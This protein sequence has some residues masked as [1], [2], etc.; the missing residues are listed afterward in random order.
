MP[1]DANSLSQSEDPN[2]PFLL[3][4][5]Q[6]AID[7]RQKAGIPLLLDTVNDNSNGCNGPQWPPRLD[8]SPTAEQFAQIIERHVPVLI[9]GCMQG[10]TALAQWRDSRYLIDRMGGKDNRVTVALTPNGRADDLVT[11][12]ETGKT[13]FA[14]PCEDQMSF[15]ELFEQFAR[16]NETST[17]Y[18]GWIAY[19]QSQNSNLSVREYGDLSPLLSDLCI[20]HEQTDSLSKEQGSTGG[21]SSGRG[22]S[23]IAW[24]TEAIGYPPE[25]TNIWIG[26]SASRTS[27]HR[28]HYENLFTVV[29]G[30]KEF[31]VFPPWEG[32]FLC[33]DVEVPVYRYK[34]SSPSNFQLEKDSD[35]PNTR[36]IA[37]DPTQPKHSSRNRPYMH[38][39]LNTDSDV[40]SSLESSPSPSSVAKYGY[41]LPP[42]RIRV[43]EGET[44]YLP[45]G[46]FHHVSQQQDSQIITDHSTGHQ[47][48]LG[49]CLCLNWWYEISDDM[50]LRLADMDLEAGVSD[51]DDDS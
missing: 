13:V 18:T 9:H 5:R 14:L 42:L 2:D 20:S 21:T 17:S 32:C 19:L 34:A 50:A 31:T 25:A 7:S 26:T 24:A 30:W 47:K 15:S 28:D 33:D 22:R 39:D 46:W 37:I 1:T 44:L 51:L 3:L 29:R 6:R 12:P 35:T 36:W 41:A 40:A 23:D 49:V 8:A 11:H 4:L 45:S 43:H 16:Q 48:D 10:R 27:M 38:R